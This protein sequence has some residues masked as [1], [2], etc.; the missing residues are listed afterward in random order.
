MSTTEYIVLIVIATLAVLFIIR[1]IV[2]LAK[3]ESPCMFCK[4]CGN[5]DEEN[6]SCCAAKKNNDMQKE[7]TKED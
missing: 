6:S 4:T 3:G 7:E 2:K 1:T 5:E